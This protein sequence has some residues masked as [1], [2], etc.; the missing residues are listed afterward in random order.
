MEKKELNL[1]CKDCNKS[2]EDCIC[3][4]DTVDIY[5]IDS[6]GVTKSEFETFRDFNK[7]ETLEEAAERTEF[8]RYGETLTNY[9]KQRP[10]YNLG[11]N[12]GTKW[13]QKHDTITTDDAYSEGFENGKKFQQERSYSDEEVLKI[14]HNYRNHFELYRNIQI[15]PNMFFEWFNKIKKK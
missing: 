10:A 2:L 13:Q 12:N 3:I 7:K 4:E 14:L 5:Y 6:F 1:E 8:E 11:F 9:T 15:L